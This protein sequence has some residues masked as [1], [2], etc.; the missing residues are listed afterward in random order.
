MINFAIQS[1]KLNN[2]FRENLLINEHIN[3]NM[4]NSCNKHFQG[5]QHKRATTDEKK[6][7]ELS[8]K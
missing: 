5:I 8:V 2:T 6:N 3:T 4:Q 1:Q 7:E